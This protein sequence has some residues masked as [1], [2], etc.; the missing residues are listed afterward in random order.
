MIKVL[1]ALG[2]VLA[3]GACGGSNPPAAT[4]DSQ[5]ATTAGPDSDSDGVADPVDKC[6]TEKE[7]GL[8]PDPKDGCPK[9]S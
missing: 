7:D 2:V 9:K 6:P 3:V 4:P 5:S 1:S 8:P